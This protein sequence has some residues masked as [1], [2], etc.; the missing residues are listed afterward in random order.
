MNIIILSSSIGD[1]LRR[2]SPPQAAKPPGPE[3]AQ[4]PA[5]LTKS[6]LPPAQECQMAHSGTLADPV[7]PNCYHR[8]AGTIPSDTTGDQ[9]PPKCNPTWCQVCQQATTKTRIQASK[10][11]FLGSQRSA[12]EAVAFSIYIYTSRPLYGGGSGVCMYFVY[13]YIIF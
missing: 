4:N 12:A 6:V 11:P 10:H 3:S 1:L 7:E 2:N 5:N 9:R 13:V 8:L